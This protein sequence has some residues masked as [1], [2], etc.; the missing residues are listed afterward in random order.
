MASCRRS[1]HL[2]L[3]MELSSSRAAPRQGQAKRMYM[4]EDPPSPVPHT[5]KHIWRRC[6]R[7]TELLHLRGCSSICSVTWG[8]REGTTII[9]LPLPVYN[10]H[11]GWELGWGSALTWNQWD[12]SMC[13]ST[14]LNWG[15]NK[16][17]FKTKAAWNP[18]LENM[19]HPH[20]FLNI[21]SETDMSTTASLLDY[22]IFH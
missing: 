12:L 10:L 16:T 4:Y 1:T 13:L 15:W 3:S 22:T 19:P 21:L 5:P 11:S 17:K 7:T 9:Y 2:L 18:V 6:I 14:L 20:S 8:Q